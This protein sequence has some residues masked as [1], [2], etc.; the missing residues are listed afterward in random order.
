MCKIL[1]KPVVNVAFNQTMSF[2]IQRMSS[3]TLVSWQSR[4]LVRDAGS[5]GNK[6]IKEWL[7]GG[8]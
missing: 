7:C 1:C 4:S 5:K 6:Q 8:E 3:E 2:E